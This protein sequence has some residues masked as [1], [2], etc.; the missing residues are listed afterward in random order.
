MYRPKVIISKREERKAV[1]LVAFLL[2]SNR[3]PPKIIFKKM[4]QLI[5]QT[6]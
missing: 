5:Y 3:L 1:D 6:N 4:L 2:Q